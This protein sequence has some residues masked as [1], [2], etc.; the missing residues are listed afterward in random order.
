M[1]KIF[2]ATSNKGKVASVNR[3][4]NKF[5]IEAIQK[6]IEIKEIQSDDPKEIASEKVLSAFKI[7]KKPV[8]ALDAGFFIPSLKGFPGAYVSYVLSKIGSEGILK[9]V[10]GKKRNCEFKEALAFF[11]SDLKKPV[12]FEDKVEGKLSFRKK[13]RRKEY[14]WSELFYVFVPKGEKKTLAEMTKKEYLNWSR[15][16]NENSYLVRFAKWYIK[17]YSK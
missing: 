12:V 10:S 8:I 5:G 2:F 13:G 6:E 15:K 7:L 14:F 4:L 17:N 3:V 1:K 11:A 9:L 16:V